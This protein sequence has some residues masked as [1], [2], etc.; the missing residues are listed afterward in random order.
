[1][2]VHFDFAG[3]VALITGGGSG[4]GRASAEAFA[5]AGASVAIADISSVNGDKVAA[6]IREAGGKAD[7]F[8]VD[9]G[10]HADVVRMV[11]EV[12]DR[13]GRLDFA[14]NNAGIEGAHVPLAEIPVDDWNRVVDIDLSSVFY[15]M[16]AEIPQMLEQGG[17][18]I[19]NTASASGLIGGF[20]LAAYTAAKHG[21][22]G[23]SKAAALDYGA[24]GI[25]VN[26]I[27]PGPIDTPFLGELPK[28]AQDKLFSNTALTRAGQAE[29]IAQAV[30]WL[31]SEG[32]SYVTGV[33]LAVDG[34]VSLGGFGTRFDDLELGAPGQ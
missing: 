22:V 11:D 34:G 25:R 13:L 3:K 7:Y 15:S 2:N 18:V 23:L 26:S 29:E 12:V 16:R 4:I 30:L 19:V 33:P 6:A 8:R 32:S 31:C 5:R 24:R 14:H 28:A 9:V 27:C 20:N 10:D 17:G 1:M 21:V